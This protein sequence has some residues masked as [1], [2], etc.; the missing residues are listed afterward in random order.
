[1]YNLPMY[2]NDVALLKLINNE[3]LIKLVVL[4]YLILNEDRN[5]ENIFIIF[6]NQTERIELFPIDYTHS[7][8]NGVLWEMGQMKRIVKENNFIS[9][10]KYMKL[11]HIHQMIMENIKFTKIEFEECTKRIYNR[12]SNIDIEEMINSVDGNILK[13]ISVSDLESFKQFLKLRIGNFQQLVED[14]AILIKED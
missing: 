2:I 3:D 5:A 7:F 1:M 4:D 11:N 14:V 9:F 10:E 8:P 6:N 13:R 12:L